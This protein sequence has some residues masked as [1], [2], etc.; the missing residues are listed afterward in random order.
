METVTAEV[1]N[2]GDALDIPNGHAK[3]KPDVLDSHSLHRF[4][5]VRMQVDVL[6]QVEA[7]PES[8]GAGTASVVGGHQ[9]DQKHWD[10]HSREVL[11]DSGKHW[12]L[13][14]WLV[15]GVLRAQ[16]LAAYQVQRPY[17]IFTELP[18]DEFVVVVF[19]EVVPQSLQAVRAWPLAKT[20]LAVDVLALR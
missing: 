2:D 11:F 13:A 18:L 10:L 5:L 6:A 7:L 3:A 20:G 9:H 8:L 12:D 16:D 1:E 14:V 4:L 19:E 15:L 17:G